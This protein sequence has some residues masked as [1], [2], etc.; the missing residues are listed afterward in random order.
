M[1]K[2]RI[3]KEQ[4][5]SVFEAWD[6]YLVRKIHLVACGGTALTIQDIKEST[7]DIDFMVPVLTEY[8]ALILTLR[9]LGYKQVTGYGWTRGDG[10][11][12]EFYEGNRIFTTELIESP[13]EKGNNIPVKTYRHL[14]VGVLN[15][16]DL[17]ISKLFR[18]AEI[19]QADCLA[20]IRA[21]REAFVLEEFEYRY[22]E[23]A[24][25]EINEEKV[26]RNLQAFLTLH[27]EELTRG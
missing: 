21:H 17:A 14:Y 23:T 22:R 15:D 27:R 5:W 2:Y 26:L 12:F 7:K 6:R 13:L 20:L 11:I 24:K 9:K 16:Y 4:L 3:G 18:G 25:Y 8:R 19:D 1:N 10:L